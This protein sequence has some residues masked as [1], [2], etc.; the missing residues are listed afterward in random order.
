VAAL[1]Q[2]VHLG[3]P[4]PSKTAAWQFASASS[5]LEKEKMNNCRWLK[6]E[7]VAQIEFAEWTPDGHLR[8][9]KFVGLRDDK[10]ARTV[11]REE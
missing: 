5:K 7:L 6:P 1:G 10:D 2:G 4:I 8:H 11:T 9:S 3:A